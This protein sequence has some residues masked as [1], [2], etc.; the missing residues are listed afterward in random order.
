MR[1]SLIAAVVP[2]AI[3]LL[4]LTGY[5]IGQQI[6]IGVP[7]SAR[8]TAEHITTGTITNVG[9][10]GGSGWEPVNGTFRIG[11]VPN[12]TPPGA[13]FHQVV[14]VYY[15]TDGNRLDTKSRTHVVDADCT[16]GRRLNQELIAQD[17]GKGNVKFASLRLPSEPTIGVKPV[18]AEG[19]T[20]AM[21]AINRSVPIANPT[22]LAAAR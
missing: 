4:G 5:S 14:D 2:S 21:M 6:S 8:L 15:D 13:I 18:T 7:S 10:A 12:P 9:W 16:P 19:R 20:K 3:I 17:D 1:K 11:P 22:Q